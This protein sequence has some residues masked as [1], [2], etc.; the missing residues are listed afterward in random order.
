MEDRTC[1]VCD[2]PIPAGRLEALPETTT[3][4]LCSRVVA[5]TE[6]DDGII[7]GADM[8]DLVRSMQTPE[9]SK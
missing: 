8:G 2:Q 5:R 7:D 6:N 1:T 4:K 9:R 3:C